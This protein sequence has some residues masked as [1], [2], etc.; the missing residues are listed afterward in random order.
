VE[1]WV[2]FQ[3]VHVGFLMARLVK[4]QCVLRVFIIF[5]L[6]IIPLM[7]HTHINSLILPTDSVVKK[8]LLFSLLLPHPYAFWLYTRVISVQVHSNQECVFIYT[9]TLLTVVTTD[10]YILLTE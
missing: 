4:G 10:T 6:S 1:A 2:R 8:N 3:A 5:C 7:L 9:L